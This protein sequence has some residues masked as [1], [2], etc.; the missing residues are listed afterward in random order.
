MRLAQSIIV[1]QRL[2]I[3]RRF[4]QRGLHD[5]SSVSC[6]HS[7]SRISFHPRPTLRYRAEMES[8]IEKAWN[9]RTTDTADVKDLFSRVRADSPIPSDIV[10]RAHFLCAQYLGGAW[11][12][13]T[14]DR[15]SIKQITGGMS[16][17][18]FLVQLCD[19]LSLHHCEPRRALLRIH[20]QSDIDQLL[21]ESVVF[22]LL[23]ER[24]LGPRLLGVFPGGRFE[25]FIPSRPLQCP[26]IS[27]HGLISKISPMVAR[28]H[29]LD[30]PIGKEPQLINRT[31]AWIDKWSKYEASKEGIDM[32]CTKAKVDQSKYPCHLSIDSLSAEIDFVEKFLESIHS[33]VIFSHNDLQEGNILLIDKEEVGD[34]DEELALIDFEYCD[35]NYRGFDLGNHLCEYGLDY[36]CEEHPFYNVYP[37]KLRMEDERRRFC[38][39]YMNELYEMESRDVRLP[40][41]LI[42]GDRT[43]DLERL[44]TEADLFMPISHIFWSCWAFLNAEQS[45]IAFGFAEYGR[46]RLAMYFEGKT[47]MEEYMRS[48]Q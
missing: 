5:D 23:S 11:K 7:S 44:E 6:V 37:E 3:R 19:T 13:S 22:T 8:S 41:D 33:P 29:S 38:S 30:V 28:V 10:S 20:C 40:C 47:R 26:E 21:S 48:H 1:L 34:N 35:Y 9:D 25:Q 4:S 36:A 39:G 27:E 12:A 45:S 46:D 31:R 42:S 43:L 2:V 32:K 17:L 14:I 15:F 24:N 16:N 18:L